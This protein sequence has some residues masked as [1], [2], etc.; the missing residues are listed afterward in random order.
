MDLIWDKFTEWLKEIL[1]GG[2]MNNL[3]GL[4]D[5]VTTRWAKSP[6]LSVLLRRRGTAAS[7]I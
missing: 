2:V 5:N 7:S 4:F 3:T 6:V 1:V